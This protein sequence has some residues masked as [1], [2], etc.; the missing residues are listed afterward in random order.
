MIQCSAYNNGTDY[1]ETDPTKAV[2]FGN[3]TLSSDPFTDAANGDFTLN[4]DAAGGELLKNVQWTD[5]SGV[6]SYYDVGTY[7]REV[8]AAS[9]GG[10]STFHPLG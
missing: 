9:G 5:A 7:Q 10:G 1:N 2:T 6:T 4:S 8:T 3:I